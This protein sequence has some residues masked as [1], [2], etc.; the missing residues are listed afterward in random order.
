MSKIVITTDQEHFDRITLRLNG[1]TIGAHRTLNANTGISAYCWEY[2]GDSIIITTAAIIAQ[3]EE[4]GNRPL[5]I[6][7]ILARFLSE[8]ENDNVYLIIHSRDLY[9]D[10]TFPAGRE[11]GESYAPLSTG[12][13]IVYRFHHNGRVWFNISRLPI[14]DNYINRIIESI[15]NQ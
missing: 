1:S 15:I 14:N 2:N 6:K 13:V 4:E 10:P 8:P 7:S 5:I 3:R 11:N 12:N 9:T